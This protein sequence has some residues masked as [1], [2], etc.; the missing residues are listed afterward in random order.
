MVCFISA[1]SP[2]TTQVITAPAPSVVEEIEEEEPAL[3]PPPPIKE[4][5]I[6]SLVGNPK[7]VGMFEK[8]PCFGKC[9]VYSITLFDDG[10]IY[11]EGK[12]NLS[13]IGKYQSQLSKAQMVELQFKAEEIGYFSLENTYPPKGQPLM[14]DFP[15][16]KTYIRI[17]NKEKIISNRHDSPTSLRQFEAYLEN[18]Y[19]ALDWIKQ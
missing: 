10:S 1:C 2:K 7:I 13:Y 11:L 6:T 5:V 14:A 17:G 12:M 3:V 18:L 16:T 4:E 15:L 8:T 9:P 19:F